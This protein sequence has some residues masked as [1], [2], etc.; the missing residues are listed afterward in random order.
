MKRIILA[1]GFTIFSFEI[2]AQ[3]I[4]LRLDTTIYVGADSMPIFPGGLKAFH[5]YIDKN[6][7][8]M[9]KPNYATGTI[10]AEV[11]IEKDGRIKNTPVIFEALSRETDSVAIYLLRNSPAWKPGSKNGRPVRTLMRIPVRFHNSSD[12]VKMQFLN[13]EET[14]ELEDELT[15]NSPWGVSEELKADDPF[16]IYTS[17]EKAPEFPGGKTGFD[18]YIN[19]GVKLEKGSKAGATDVVV[20]FIVEKD[21]SLTDIKIIEGFSDFFNNEALRLLRQSPKWTPGMK[22][23]FPVRTAF[24]AMI[25]FKP[26]GT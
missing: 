12:I 1:G 2:Y 23:G 6:A 19:Q 15:I 3:N 16:R 21:G 7:P 24:S 8:K 9:L 22:N 17:V 14:N 4:D 26:Q 18:N 25:R 5:Q 20:S 10:I 11:L 13:T